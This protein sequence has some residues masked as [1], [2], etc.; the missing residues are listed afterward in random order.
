MVEM[1][2][3]NAGRK[4]AIQQIILKWI[5]LGVDAW[6]ESKMETLARYCDSADEF[7]DVMDGK[8]TYA[9]VRAR[10]KEL[11][12][13]ERQRK[14]SGKVGRPRQFP[15]RRLDLQLFDDQWAALDSLVGNFGLT[16]RQA[17]RW[18][19]SEGI[20]ALKRVEE[21]W[22]EMQARTSASGA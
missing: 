1:L 8:T 19:I 21:R 13:R 20:D 18:F 15:N 17:I 3:D 12:R 22:A 7:W 2:E 10:L 5:E 14:K 6:H 16:Q 11:Q 9:S 4:L